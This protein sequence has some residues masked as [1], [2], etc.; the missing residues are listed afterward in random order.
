MTF[1]VGA[2]FV[3]ASWLVGPAVAAAVLVE[4]MFGVVIILFFFVQEL[5][6]L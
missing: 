4:G 1:V 5:R 3:Y 2:S 6:R